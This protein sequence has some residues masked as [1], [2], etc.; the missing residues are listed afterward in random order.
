[1]LLNI[2]AVIIL[3]A[4]GTIA[5]Q[6]AIRAKR[7]INSEWSAENQ[8]CALTKTQLINRSLVFYAK[9]TSSD[10]CCIGANL[11][12]YKKLNLSESRN[13]SE[14]DFLESPEFPCQTNLYCTVFREI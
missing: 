12:Y 4:L 1:M 3:I 5:M 10:S 14:F 9:I 2:T 8:T 7:S 6:A 11:L 13:V